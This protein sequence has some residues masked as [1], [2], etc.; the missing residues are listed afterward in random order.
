MPEL[1]QLLP[2]TKVS[3]WATPGIPVPTSPA[4]HAGYFAGGDPFVTTVDRFAFPSDSRTTLA[5]GLSVLRGAGAAMANSSVAGYVCGG[6]TTGNIGS[7]FV[8][9]FDFSDDSRSSLLYGLLV[10][11]TNLP[12]GFANSGTAGYIAGG[13]GPDTNN[14]ATDN[15]DKFTFSNDSRAVLGTGLSSNIQYLAGMANSGTAGYACAGYSGGANVDDVDKFTFSNDSR[16]ALSALLSQSSRLPAAMAN[17][18]TAGYIAGG[19]VSGSSS[20]IDRIAFSNDACTTLGATLSAGSYS[21]G[22][23][24]DSGTAGY[25]GGGTGLGSS[26]NKIEFSGET[27]SISA[28]TLSTSARNYLMGFANCGV[29]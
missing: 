21:H 26:L 29:L 22:G 2:S 18:G 24:A 13:A 20:T 19:T 6:G 23:F 12:A 7:A 14:D 8:D 25:Y 27:R 11:R 28:G 17:S 4:G 3:D 1:H 10:G 15:V 16:S 9:K 5:I